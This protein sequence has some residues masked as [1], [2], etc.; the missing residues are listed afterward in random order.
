M[1]RAS[2]RRRDGHRTR[3][4]AR[5]AASYLDDASAREAF[6]RWI[7]AYYRLSAQ[8]LAKR[9]G[10]AEIDALTAAECAR[11]AGVANRA[12]VV[13]RWMSDLLA[14]EAKAGRLSEMRL[15]AIDGNLSALNDYLGGAERIAK[16]PLPFAYA[17]HIKV[18]VALFCFTTPFAIVDAMGWATP[19]VSGLLALALFGIDEIGVEIEDPFGDDPNDLPLDAIGD[20]IERAVAETL[21]AG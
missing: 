1:G 10:L 17:Q 18:F 3:D 15:Y 12:P 2:A 9:D 4:L 19:V 14:A 8:T 20:G 16:T 6:A 13:C 7:R 5:Q 21:A 11:L